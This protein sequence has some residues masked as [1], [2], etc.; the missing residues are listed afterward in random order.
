V[1]LDEANAV[2][3]DVLPESSSVVLV[4]VG[5]AEAI[6]SGLGKYGPVTEMKLADPSFA[7]MP[8]Q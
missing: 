8:Q 3:G 6:R 5:K 1:T 4:V 2:I 7:P